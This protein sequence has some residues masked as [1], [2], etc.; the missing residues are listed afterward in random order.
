MKDEGEGRGG[1]YGRT[2]D[3]SGAVCDNLFITQE[4]GIRND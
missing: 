3:Q 4:T 1:V 2:G